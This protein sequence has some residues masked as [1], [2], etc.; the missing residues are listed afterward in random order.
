M[1]PHRGAGRRAVSVVS[2]AVVTPPVAAVL[3]VR[4]TVV[5]AAAAAGVTGTHGREVHETSAIPEK[6]EVKAA[7]TSAITNDEPTRTKQRASKR[8]FGKVVKKIIALK[9]NAEPHK[10]SKKGKSTANKGG[11]LALSRHFI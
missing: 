1:L 7:L 10:R 2:V 5:A 11:N 8:A 3:A 9:S 6:R 4:R